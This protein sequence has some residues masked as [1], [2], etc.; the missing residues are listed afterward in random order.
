MVSGE[1]PSIREVKGPVVTL[2][3]KPILFK[4]VNRVEHDPVHGKTVPR[5]AL[6]RDLHLMKQHNINCLR[7]AH[8]PHDTAL[9]ELCDEL[10]I[11]VIDEANVESHGMRYGEESLAK[12]PEWKA[13]HVERAMNMVERDKNHPSVVMWS[14]GNEAGK[15]PHPEV[16]EPTPAAPAFTRGFSESLVKAAQGEVDEI[17]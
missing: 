1:S 17:G 9:Y 8:Y 11:L 10:G 3:G 2:N 6:E 15:L 12:Q 5:E 13:Q 16:K 14:H 7:T 4:G